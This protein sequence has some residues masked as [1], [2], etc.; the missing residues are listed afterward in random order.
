MGITDSLKIDL[1]ERETEVVE[2]TVSGTI[3]T[4]LYQTF[5]DNNSSQLLAGKLAEV[6]AWQIDFYTIQKGD[7]F[8]ALYEQEKVGDAVVKIG[9]ILAAKFIHKGNEYNAFL[10][11]Q[12]GKLEYFD[13]NGGSLQKAFLK[14]PLKFKRISS[15]FSRN[16]LH[17]ILRVY[18]PH[19][20]IDFAAAIGTPVQAVGDGIVVEARRNGA[21]G[22]YVKIKHNSAYSSGYMHLSKY[23][24][25]IRNGVRV[26]QGQIIGYVGSTGRST[27]PHLDFR[28]W[29]NGALV[30]YLTQKFPSS[31]SVSKENLN[32][33]YTFKDSLQAKI[34]T[35]INLNQIT[36]VREP[37]STL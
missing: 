8:F 5:I 18:K 29:K 3:N 26:Q 35:L 37:E 4:S 32:S 23:G 34:D 16:R 36:L 9:D 14:A 22:N 12:D 19:L 7:S 27:G 11:N 2:N 6:F 21:A 1:V 31:K 20:G 10:Y 25:G 28:F 24:K 13:E 15:S 30:N 33:Y 17:P